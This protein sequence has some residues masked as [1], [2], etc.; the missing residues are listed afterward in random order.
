MPPELLISGVPLIVI[1]PAAVQLVKG[2][3]LATRWAGIASVLSCAVLLGLLELQSHPVYGAIA[4]WATV[5]LVYGLAAA[6]LYSQAKKLTE[7]R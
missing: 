3:G 5:S 4:T 6:G 1:V 7:G 2:L